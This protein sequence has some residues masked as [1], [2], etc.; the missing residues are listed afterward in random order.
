M[1]H[2]EFVLIII[3]GYVIDIMLNLL[4]V[5]LVLH[6][7]SSVTNI[8]IFEWIH[9]S[10]NFL[11]GL[12]LGLSV[13][14]LSAGNLIESA[15]FTGVWTVASYFLAKYLIGF[16]SAAKTLAFLGMDTVFDFAL[17]AMIVIPIGIGNLSLGLFSSLPQSGV[18]SDLALTS[19]PLSFSPVVIIVSTLFGIAMLF[20]KV[21][22]SRHQ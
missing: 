13:L 3:A 6:V 5:K 9:D 20:V 8:A 16:E 7:D 11:A 18:A 15:V 19:T 10:L 2:L 22:Q 21:R 14:S 12:F 1:Q 17:G 4:V